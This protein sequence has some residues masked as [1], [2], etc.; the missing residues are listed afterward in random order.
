MLRPHA[1]RSSASNMH[2]K[3]LESPTTWNGVAYCARASWLVDWFV[4]ALIEQ[5]SHWLQSKMFGAH[6]A[7]LR[8]AVAFGNTR[9]CRVSAGCSN[10]DDKRASREPKLLWRRL[11][12]QLA[13]RLPWPLYVC[14]DRNLRVHYARSRGHVQPNHG[15]RKWARSWRRSFWLVFP[16]FFQHQSRV[17]I[18][19]SPPADLGT[20]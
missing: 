14:I 15:E 19:P 9:V 5:P 17:S 4:G 13:Q 10:N 2:S 3:L 6:P 16:N 7:F 18:T 8:L 11:C 12:I 1:K 20:M